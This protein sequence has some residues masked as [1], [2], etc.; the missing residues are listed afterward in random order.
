MEWAEHQLF[1]EE[2]VGG[3]VDQH[4]VRPESGRVAVERSRT[5]LQHEHS[6]TVCTHNYS[7]H[8]LSEKEQRSVLTAI[9]IKS[10]SKNSFAW[11]FPKA[12]QLVQGGANAQEM[13]K[14]CMK[15]SE[16]AWSVREILF[17]QVVRESVCSN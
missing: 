14:M 6:Q 12:S 9:L 1:V 8:S 4:S 16:K 5:H 13:K 3:S 17:L 7:S 15:Q 10:H 2:S 11:R